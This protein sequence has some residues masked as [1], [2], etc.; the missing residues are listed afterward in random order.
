MI[1][2]LTV[3]AGKLTAV[4]GRWV[5]GSLEKFSSDGLNFLSKSSS[6]KNEDGGRGV[7]SLKTQI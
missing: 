6:V 2:A 1:R 4:T 5:D 3:Q 7:G